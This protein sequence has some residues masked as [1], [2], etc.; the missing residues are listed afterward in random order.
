MR[1]APR[2]TEVILLLADANFAAARGAFDVVLAAESLHRLPATID[3]ASLLAFLAP[4]GILV[5]IEPKPSLF[6]DI[7]FGLDPDW[8]ATD[9][10]DYPIGRLRQANQWRLALERAGF[11]NV[12]A[13]LV[14]CGSGLASLIVAERAASPHQDAL[15]SDAKPPQTTL[16]LDALSGPASK[17]GPLLEGL[18]Q[19]QA[20]NATLAHRLDFSASCA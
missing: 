19:H 17:I 7:A 18:L 14:A 3:L 13:Q 12:E 11:A 2:P 1:S 6:R 15:T 9:A 8:F 10:P 5:A 4:R 16:I 20:V